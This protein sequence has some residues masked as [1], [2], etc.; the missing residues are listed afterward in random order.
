M[1][2]HDIAHSSTTTSEAAIGTQNV[3]TLSPAWKLSVKNVIAAA[4]TVVNGVLYVGDWAGN[5][6]AVDAN[7]GNIL[8]QEFVGISADPDQPWCMPATGVSSQ[9][10]VIGDTVYVGGGD[11]AVYAFDTKSGY[12]RWRVPIAKPTTGAYL[13]S[14]VVPSGNSI[15]IGIASLADCPLTRGGLVRMDL[16]DPTNPVTRYLTPENT[17][18]AGVWSTPAIDP[19]TNTVFITTG[20][21]DQDPDSELWGSTFMSVDAT[22]LTTKSYYLLP[23]Y[24]PGADIEWGSS[25]TLIQTAD[26]QRLVAAT[27]KDGVLYALNQDDLSVGWTLRLAV[28]C[29]CPECGCGSLSTPAYDG[30]LLY[31]G[32]GVADPEG[33]DNGSVYAIN[34]SNGTVV[35]MR[36]LA[37]TVLA[38]VT[39]ANGVL[40]VSTLTG[41]QVY[42]AAS[43]DALWNDGMGGALYSQP[44]V[45]N[46]TVYL[47]YVGGDIVAFKPS[48]KSQSSSF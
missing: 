8:W 14:S 41:L 5:F 3:A 42:D 24:D 6:Y 26:G 2:L 12:R 27:A 30:K 9:A 19:A 15:Y 37:D 22:T 25:P 23:S 7:A 13:W 38:P 33:F 48:S 39:V 40:F 21:G 43:G 1:Y 29:V 34:P 11:S 44:V 45:T 20:T 28:S 47:T 31:V 4:P 35:W 32:A 36:S 17:Q 18:G 16:S 10:T 46:G